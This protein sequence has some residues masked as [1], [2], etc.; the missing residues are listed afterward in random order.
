MKNTAKA[1]NYQYQPTKRKKKRKGKIA[2]TIVLV[3][4]GLLLIAG[5]YGAL[6]VKHYVDTYQPLAE[7]AVK[8]LDL[9]H[10]PDQHASRIYYKN[11]KTGKWKVL[12]TLFDGQ[13]NEWVPYDEFPKCLIN[14]TIAIE[15]KRFFEHKGVDWKRTISAG[16]RYLILNDPDSHGG[17][18]L[19]QQLMKNLTQKKEVTK[20]RKIQEIL[21]ALEFEKSH[22]KEEILELYLNDIY[23]A[24]NCV[25]AYRAARKYFSKD[26]RDLT[27]TEAALLIGI[28]NNPEFYDPYVHPSNTKERGAVVITQMY[29]QEMIDRET[30]DSCLAEIGYTMEVEEPTGLFAQWQDTKYPLTYHKD[31]DH[32]EFKDGSLKVKTVTENSKHVYSWYTDAVL[33]RLLKEL[34][35]YYSC[36]IDEANHLLYQGGLKIYTCLD[37]Q[38]QKVV[39]LEYSNRELTAFNQAWGQDEPPQ[40]AITVVDNATG[41]VVALSGGLGKKKTSR[42]W[43]RAVDTARPSGSSIKPLGVYGPAIDLGVVTPDTKI[44]DSMFKKDEN[45]NPW[46]VNADGSNVGMMTVHDALVKSVNTVAVKTLDKVGLDKSYYY[47][48]ER[49]HLT[50]ILPEDKDYAPMAL[51]GFTNGVSTF[52]MAGAFSVFPRKGVYIE[53]HLYT[54]VKDYKGKTI[55]RHGKKKEKAVSPETANTMNYMMRDAVLFGTGTGAQLGYMEAAGKTGTTSNSYDLWFCGFTPYYTA[56]VWTGYDTQIAMGNEGANPSVTIWRDIMYQINQGKEWQSL[57]SYEPKA[58][59]APEKQNDRDD[60]KEEDEDDE[61]EEQEHAHGGDDWIDILFGD[62]D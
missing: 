45:G 54:V 21:E 9:S 18:S 46:P 12:E 44:E 5:A 29:D 14:A 33:S 7:K 40:S 62:D 8:N 26:V 51:G 49:F 35:A 17:S 61:E 52:D 22:S 10:F 28:P 11:K 32:F 16:Y 30:A 57:S 19:T 50:T 55:I 15:D 36:D 3:I 41:K 37:P 2:L 24:N 47:L 39:D 6:T 53:P 1:L 59:A 42:M 23:Y 27:V 48:T 20:E 60:E 34:M 43:N 13:D 38:V 56:A 4:V 58:P 31:M 25:G